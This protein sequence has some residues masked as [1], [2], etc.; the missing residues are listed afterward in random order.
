MKAIDDFVKRMRKQDQASALTPKTRSLATSGT[1]MIKCGN[2]G[3]VDDIE[4]F[5]TAPMAGGFPNDIYQCPVCS[6]AIK[7]ICANGKL[8]TKKIPTIW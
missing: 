7:R 1:V 5:T 6:T 2:C 3:H 4:L 8:Q